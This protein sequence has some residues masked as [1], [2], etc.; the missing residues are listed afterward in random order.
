[1]EERKKGCEGGREMPLEG[2]K[3]GEWM[4]LLCGCHCFVGAIG[5]PQVGEDK[6]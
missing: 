3:E 2:R 5:P 1:M 4:L 6:T